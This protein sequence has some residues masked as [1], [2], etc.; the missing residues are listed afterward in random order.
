MPAS[1]LFVLAHP[2]LTISRANRAIAAT[3]RGIEGIDVLDLYDEYPDLFVDGGAE[4]RRIEAVSAIVFQ[5]PFFW[6][7]GPSLLKEWMDRTFTSRWAYGQGGHRA[8]GKSLTVSITTGSDSGAWAPTGI[9]G[10][11]AEDYLKPYH[12][13]ARFCGMHWHDP[14]VLHAS[15]TVSD[16]SLAHHIG[17]LREHL[18]ALAAKAE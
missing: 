1:V 18:E 2:D 7:S 17:R 12:Q 14:F 8:Q 10:A 3:A 13:F 15:R 11:P 5:M 9:H 16:E 4:R 6:Y